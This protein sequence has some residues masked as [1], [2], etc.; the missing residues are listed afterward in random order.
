MPEVIDEQEVYLRRLPKPETLP[1]WS[2]WLDA[3]W[4]VM[5]RRH[6][7]DFAAIEKRPN[8]PFM[9]KLAAHLHSGTETEDAEV[10]QA[11]RWAREEI[12]EIYGQ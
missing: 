3:A 7:P 10:A 1:Q 12:A 5:K 2:F 6:A 9:E 11:L 4:P 8:G